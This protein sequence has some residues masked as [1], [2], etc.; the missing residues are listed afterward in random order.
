[1]WSISILHIVILF[2]S[3]IYIYS[4]YERNSFSKLTVG[5]AVMRLSED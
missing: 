3:T 4:M 1:M 5:S 2:N